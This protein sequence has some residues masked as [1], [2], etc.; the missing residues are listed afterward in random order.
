MKSL[1]EKIEMIKNF[2]GF[3]V[4]RGYILYE[5]PNR[6][7]IQW[8]GANR[9]EHTFISHDY[10]QVLGRCVQ[11]LEKEFL[12][13]VLG[14]GAS[15]P[16]NN[17]LFNDNPQLYKLTWNNKL[18]YYEGN[19]S[20]VDDLSQYTFNYDGNKNINWT[21]YELN[22]EE[23]VDK[24]AGNVAN[25]T[26]YKTVANNPTQEDID[27]FLFNPENCETI[28]LIFFQIQRFLIELNNLYQQGKII[29]I[30]P[31]KWFSNAIKCQ[32][33]SLVLYHNLLKFYVNTSP[34][35]YQTY[36]KQNIDIDNSLKLYN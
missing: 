5:N 34:S 11:T 21:G 6:Q 4:N 25:G 24:Q 33:Q 31:A 12:E 35:Y 14:V 8:K 7:V 2:E 9:F 27:N 36:F 22:I 29:Q 3:Y 32:D 26:F 17:K 30:I 18:E 19:L 20:D 1:E 15:S 13:E 23:N 10:N 16:V 28:S